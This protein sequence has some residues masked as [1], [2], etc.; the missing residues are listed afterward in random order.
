MRDSGEESEGTRFSLPFRPKGNLSPLNLRSVYAERL[1][2][3]KMQNRP[4]M[5]ERFRSNLFCPALAKML[6]ILARNAWQHLKGVP[7]PPSLVLWAER[8]ARL[9]VRTSLGTLEDRTRKRNKKKTKDRKAGTDILSFSR[10]V[11]QDSAMSPNTGQGDGGA[12]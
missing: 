7:A 12:G 9:V 11:A 4:S 5:T 1:C 3:E 10:T 2:D 6:A 8:P